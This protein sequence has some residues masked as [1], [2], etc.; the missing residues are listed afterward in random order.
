LNLGCGS[1]TSADPEVVNVD[2]SIYLR[3][4]RSPVLHALARH[5]LDDARSKKLAALDVN[6]LVH[7]LSKGIPAEDASVDV[8][9]HSH[10]L[11]HLDRS[12][13]Q[14]FMLETYRV[15]KP[16]GVH[17]IV[18]PDLARLAGDYLAHL[19]T[20]DA[21][22]HDAYV[23]ALIEQSVRREAHG[24]S[25]KPRLRRLIENLVLG[26]ARRRGETHQWM[27]D[28]K[29][30]TY[31]LQQSRF[32]QITCVLYNTSAVTDWNRFA[33]DLQSDGT[34]YKPGSLYMECRKA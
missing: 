6:I 12:A 17:R 13:A 3:L 7:D 31:L 27:Y 10:L 2:W 24:T 1:K 5:A 26:D 8:V 33:L 23:G 18:V 25:S 20:G 28:T 16:G 14:T 9:Y 4:K 15:L 32:Q 21:A 11:E 19:D 29:N 22:S 30:L 34:E